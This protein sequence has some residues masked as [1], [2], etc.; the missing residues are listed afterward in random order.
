LQTVFLTWTQDQGGEWGWGDSGE[1]ER[2]PKEEPEK[3]EEPEEPEPTDE[4]TV[5]DNEDWERRQAARGAPS[6]RKAS[7]DVPAKKFRIGLEG[8][9]FLPLGAKE[10]NFNTSGAGGVALGFGLP[11][12]IDGL[13]ITSEIRVLGA[14]TS[15]KD[16]AGGF[17]VSSTLVLLKGDFLFHFFPNDGKFNLFAFVG[18]GGGYESATAEPGTSGS[19]LQEDSDSGMWFLAQGGLG[20]WINLGGPIDLVLKLEFNLIPTSDNV[21]FFIMGEGGLQL[22]F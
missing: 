1:A 22:R 5:I 7:E 12:L 9:L 17:D 21:P 11:P 3:E 10:E 6:S 13:T 14:R 2:G 4:S 16:Q 20:T 18:I 19:G 15:S 8:G